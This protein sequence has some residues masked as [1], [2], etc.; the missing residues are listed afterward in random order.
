VGLAAPFLVPLLFGEDFAAAARF[1]AILLPGIVA[2]APV[3]ILVV[4]LS[5]RRGPPRRSLAVSLAAM[6][7]TTIGAVVLI[8]RY[9][10]SGAAA[11]SALGYVAGGLLAWIFFVR[12]AGLSILG[13]SRA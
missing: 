13:R 10:G 4:Y 6:V 2:Y 11:A 9:G 8:P 12:V 5:I 3:T 7:L 1:L